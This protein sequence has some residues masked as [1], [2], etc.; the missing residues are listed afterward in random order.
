MPNIKTIGY[1]AFS[2]CNKLNSIYLGEDVTLENY[3]IFS[4]NTT[5]YINRYEDPKGKDAKKNGTDIYGE[6]YKN[7]GAKDI[8]YLDDIRHPNNPNNPNNT[9][10]TKT[11]TQN[12][13]GGGGVV[14][15]QPTTQP[16]T[17]P[18]ITETTTETTTQTVTEEK[19]ETTTE[20][21]KEEPTETTTR[22]N[23][24]S[25]V[26]I[27]GNNNNNTNNSVVINTDRNNNTNNNTDINNIGLIGENDILNPIIEDLDIIGD[28][29]LGESEE[30]LLNDIK[31]EN[32]IV[33]RNMLSNSSKSLLVARNNDLANADNEEI[34]KTKTDK[35]AFG[36]A[37]STMSWLLILLIIL[38]LIIIVAYIIK[39]KLSEK[40]LEKE[41]E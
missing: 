10:T 32:I 39:K 11:T 24:N 28:G 9:T 1:G 27:G 6:E 23:F 20:S 14:I 26:I 5:V 7:W 3:I 15:I 33:A 37:N 13:N 40:A 4:D 16:T 18:N 34:S 19:T 38:V 29:E 31:E 25:G 12:N 17:Q 2:D 41:E 8:I 30:L 36:F 21:K 22:N 35:P